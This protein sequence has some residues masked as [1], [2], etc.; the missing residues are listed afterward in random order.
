MVK[1][2]NRNFSRI[3]AIRSTNTIVPH[4][5][6]ENLRYNKLLCREGKLKLLRNKSVSFLSD[7]IY[8]KRKPKT[9]Q[10]YLV[11]SIPDLHGKFNNTMK[12]T[13]GE[14]HYKSYSNNSYKINPKN[15]NINKST[16]SSSF[17][18]ENLKNNTQKGTIKNL[19]N[20]NGIL[21]LG[22][23]NSFTK[24]L[25]EAVKGSK[26]NM[27]SSMNNNFNYFKEMSNSR[28]SKDKMKASRQRMNK[29]K[30][31]QS[32]LFLGASRLEPILDSTSNSTYIL[33]PKI[34]KRIILYPEDEPKFLLK[35]SRKIKIIQNNIN[36]KR[37]FLHK[38]YLVKHPVLNLIEKK[39]ENRL[40][41]NIIFGNPILDDLKDISNIDNP[42]FN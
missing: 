23:L 26:N 32:P 12:L 36:R 18:D 2:Y 3:T 29:I 28:L 1:S 30:S 19:Q 13:T 16:F 34:P 37:V 7:I 14:T 11:S 33:Y 39:M 21:K 8:G 42:S 38:R 5:R 24:Y 20:F 17:S 41:Y 25:K 35:K 4:P 10:D 27:E 22:L 9:Q 15:F 40:L 31:L 6:K